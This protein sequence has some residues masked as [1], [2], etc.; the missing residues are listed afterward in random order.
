[1]PSDVCANSICRAIPFCCP[2]DHWAALI[3]LMHRGSAAWQPRLLSGRCRVW[4][5]LTP[6][7]QGENIERWS[8]SS[9]A[10]ASTWTTSRF[11][12]KPTWFDLDMLINGER[13]GASPDQIPP[14]STSPYK[15][16]AGRK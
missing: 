3:T 10:A 6:P 16:I 13:S 9:L 11:P 8:S 5:T 12:G 1:M 2:K 15:G 7:D 14:T 4:V